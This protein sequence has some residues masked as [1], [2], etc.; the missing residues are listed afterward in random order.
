MLTTTTLL[1][2]RRKLDLSCPQ[3]MG[4]LNV[5]PDSFSDGGKF[6]SMQAALAHAQA[7]VGAGA[8]IIDVGGESTRPGAKAVSEQEELDRV[9]PIVEMLSSELDVIVSV[10]TSTAKVMREAARAGAGMIND[11]RALARESAGRCVRRQRGPSTRC[12]RASRWCWGGRRTLPWPSHETAPS[13]RA[14]DTPPH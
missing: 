11:V 4:V 14:A 12:T 8:A 6:T 10:D 1:C 9:I 13:E 3:I 5:T 2:G 7:M